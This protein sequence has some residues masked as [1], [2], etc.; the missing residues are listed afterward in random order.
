MHGGGLVVEV[1]L[2]SWLVRMAWWRRQKPVSGAGLVWAADLTAPETAEL[3]C[4]DCVTGHGYVDHMGAGQ[5]SCWEGGC[6]S[7]D[8]TAPFKDAFV[9]N[10]KLFGRGRDE[11][12]SIGEPR[13]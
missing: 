10:L 6:E 12:A 11:L 13:D 8:L 5:D 4:V 2:F 1:V 3:G 9:Q 7:K